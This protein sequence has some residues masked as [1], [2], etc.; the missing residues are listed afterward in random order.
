MSD[1]RNALE[2]ES[3]D[4]ERAEKVSRR[5]FNKFLML[6]SLAAAAGAV[7]VLSNGCSKTY[8]QL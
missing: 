6:G 2:K 8:P 3:F 4:T 1:E 5:G 7:G